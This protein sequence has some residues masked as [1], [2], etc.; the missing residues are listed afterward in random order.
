MQESHFFLLL[1]VGVQVGV[2]IGEINHIVAH[3][4]FALDKLSPASRSVFEMLPFATQQ[5]LLLDRDPHGNVQ[6]ALIQT[7]KLLLELTT[8]ELKRRG[9]KGTFQGRCSYLGSDAALRLLG[10]KASAAGSLLRGSATRRRR[11]FADTK[12]GVDFRATLTRPT[13]TLS[14]TWLGPSFKTKCEAAAKAST[15]QRLR[16]IPSGVASKCAAVRV[17][18]S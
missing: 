14:A 4:D 2:L 11:F 1:V 17:S 18:L 15:K 6:V 16:V 12:D 3:G 7:E 9:F 13:A 10:E 8:E 5:Q